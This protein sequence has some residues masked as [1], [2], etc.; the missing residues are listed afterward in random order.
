MVAGILNFSD[1]GGFSTG[2]Y[3]LMTY[4]TNGLGTNVFVTATISNTPNPAFTY[5]LDTQTV[6][7][8]KLIV[9]GTPAAPFVVTGIARTGNDVKITWST[10]GG[11]VDV[12]EAAD[13]GNYNTN[14]FVNISGSM[15]IPG[16]GPQSTNYT[17]VGGALNKTNRFYR[18]R[19]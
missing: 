12:V 3:N 9:S 1:S 5:T 6:G 2:T 8:V 13:G 7:I 15:T 14:N 16:S 18:V 19:H 11:K 10:E 4:N 17:D